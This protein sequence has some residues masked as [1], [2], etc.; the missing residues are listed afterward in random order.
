[1]PKVVS[2]GQKR[3]QNHAE[4]KT[5]LYYLHLKNMLLENARQH[6]YLLI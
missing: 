2:C 4:S 1:M 3:Y 5:K 6:N